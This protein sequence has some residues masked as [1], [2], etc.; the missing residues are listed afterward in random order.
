MH[1]RV[2]FA[3][4]SIMGERVWMICRK[5]DVV[6]LYLTEAAHDFTREEKE[7][8]LEEAWSGYRAMSEA[9]PIPEQQRRVQTRQSR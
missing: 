5:A 9:G 3:A 1:H 2:R 8:Y 4:P 6:T 7:R